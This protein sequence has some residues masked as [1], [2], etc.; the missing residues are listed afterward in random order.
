[1]IYFLFLG[2]FANYLTLNGSL[3]HKA[4]TVPIMWHPAIIN[5]KWSALTRQTHNPLG[6]DICLGLENVLS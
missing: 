2:I 3:N 1:M 5:N 6:T 4:Y